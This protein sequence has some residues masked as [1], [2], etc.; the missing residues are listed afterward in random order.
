MTVALILLK[1]LICGLGEG[2]SNYIKSIHS[3][4]K[5]IAVH[6]DNSYKLRVEKLSKH[7]T[8][9]KSNKI[10]RNSQMLPIMFQYLVKKPS[11]S[12]TEN[13]GSF[14]SKSIIKGKSEDYSRTLEHNCNRT[15][16]SNPSRIGIEKSLLIPIE[17]AVRFHHAAVATDNDLCS[18]IGRDILRMG[19]S[20]VDTAIAAL[21]CLG[22]VHFQSSGIGGSGSMIVYKKD[23]N[24]VDGFDFSDMAPGA[25]DE[26]TFE[27]ARASSINGKS[28]I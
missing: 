18:D 22:T 20:A 21:L 17:P 9:R 6:D 16:C 11:I 28:L 27:D 1:H 25:I 12:F 26:D 15:V 4:S 19:G 13:N 14:S 24:K 23:A 8:M 5:S 7:E 10:K 3:S 2:P